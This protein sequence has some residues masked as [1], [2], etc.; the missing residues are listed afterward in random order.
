MVP[1]VMVKKL[2]SSDIFESELQPSSNL[3]TAHFYGLCDLNT[4]SSTAA[5]ATSI[6]IGQ[7]L[8]ILS[9]SSF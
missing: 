6:A 3:S 5:A 2:C 8:P 9:L 7:S 4:F 1:G